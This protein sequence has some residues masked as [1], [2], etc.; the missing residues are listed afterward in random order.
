MT[1]QQSPASCHPHLVALAGYLCGMSTPNTVQVGL[2]AAKLGDGPSDALI[3]RGRGTGRVGQLCSG[4]GWAGGTGAPQQDTPLIPS[5]LSPEASCVIPLPQH[6][7]TEASCYFKKTRLPVCVGPSQQQSSYCI[8]G[9]SLN[10]SLCSGRQTVEAERSRASASGSHR[11]R[12]QLCLCGLH[13][14]MEPRA[15]VGTLGRQSHSCANKHTRR[16][17]L[18]S[19]E[20]AVPGSAHIW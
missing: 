14:A 1:W 5:W 6:W 20:P 8:P 13:P 11:C 19:R 3:L 15:M 4:A 16:R 10:A 9:V 18:Q 17:M 12:L 7:G 2:W